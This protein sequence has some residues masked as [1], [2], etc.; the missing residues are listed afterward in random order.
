MRLL[1]S[2]VLFV[3]LSACGNDDGSK[4]V[5]NFA[6]Q[7]I[8]YLGSS[9]E[10]TL[11]KGV[12]S[13]T[14]SVAFNDPMQSVNSG[15]SFTLDF[16]LQE[17]GELTLVTYA[18]KELKNGYE[19]K[20]S[21]TGSEVKAHLVADGKEQDI[22]AAFAELDFSKTVS[23]TFDIHN[24]ETPGHV[25]IWETTELAEVE[26]VELEEHALVN[27]AHG[28][29]DHADDEEAHAEEEEEHSEDESHHHETLEVES[30]G[31]GSGTFWGVQI[32]KATLNSAKI[33]DPTFEE[34]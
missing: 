16:S 27:T 23:L 24:N 33:A 9:D 1:Y 22:S 12:L 14:G 26:A 34:E 6:G 10:I 25:L 7:E 13:G 28:H 2:I 31:N 17:G 3:G 5:E 21:R 19:V 30:P 15:H 11:E 32:V 20:F 18:S 4:D 8:V 29:E